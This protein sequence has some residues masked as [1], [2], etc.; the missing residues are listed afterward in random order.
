MEL[1]VRHLRRSQ[2]RI[3]AGRD[4]AGVARSCSRCGDDARRG[5][6][7]GAARDW[8]AQLKA[9]ERLNALQVAILEEPAKCGRGYIGAD[10]VQ[11]A[12]A[13]AYTRAPPGGGHA[14]ADRVERDRRPDEQPDRNSCV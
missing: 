13:D 9:T 10:G 4:A 1:A 12:A 14:L 5:I 6:E 11:P 7:Y 8:R 3:V 2:H